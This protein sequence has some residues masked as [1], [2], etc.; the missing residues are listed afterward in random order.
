MDIGEH[1]SLHASESIPVNNTESN[2]KASIPKIYSEEC[3]TKIQFMELL[4]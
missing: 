1:V 3:V 2:R 4:M